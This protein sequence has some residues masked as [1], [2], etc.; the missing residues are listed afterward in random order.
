MRRRILTLA[1]AALFGGLALTSDA[2]A[3]H[4]RKRCGGGCGGGLI[5]RRGCGHRV[6]H[7][8]CGGCGGGYAYG[9]HSYTYPPGVW[10]GGTTAAG[11][12]GGYGMPGMP[13]MP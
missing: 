6:R 8:G 2:E 13:G 7:P 9:G 12:M 3:C 10:G 4:G 11:Q 5:A 1:M